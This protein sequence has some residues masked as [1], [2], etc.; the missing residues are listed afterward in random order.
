MEF[1]KQQ[2]QQLD[3]KSSQYAQSELA[4]GDQGQLIQNYEQDI[5]M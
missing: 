1:V 5:Q 4:K 2:K 3:D